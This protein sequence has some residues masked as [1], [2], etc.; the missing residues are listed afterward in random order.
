MTDFDDIMD[1]MFHGCA[2]AAYIEEAAKAGGVP[3]SE[4]TRRLAFRYFEAALAEK[5][6]RRNRLPED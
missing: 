5:Q 3:C 6:G 2:L 1:D 4:L